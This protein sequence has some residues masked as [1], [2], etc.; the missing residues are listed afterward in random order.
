[1]CGEREPKVPPKDSRERR[2]YTA[3]FAVRDG[4]AVPEQPLD[5]EFQERFET[6]TDYEWK[7]VYPPPDSEEVLATFREGNRALREDRIWEAIDAYERCLAIEDYVPA[8]LN[9]AVAHL[10]EAS[11]EGWQKC[12]SALRE[13]I[14]RFEGPYAGQA[15]SEMKLTKEQIGSVLGPAYRNMAE[16]LT[17]RGVRERSEASLREALDLTRA[18]LGVQPGNTAWLLELWGILHLLGEADEATAALREAGKNADFERLSGHAKE[19]YTALAV[20]Y[21]SR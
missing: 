20:L 2:A 5:A 1:M 8:R 11:A 16:L 14:G 13:L 9:L 12:Q 3:Q 6:Q 4:Q 15:P 21:H 18:A 17:Q 10:H 19:K 7:R